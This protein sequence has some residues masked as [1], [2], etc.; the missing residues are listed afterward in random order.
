MV[1][2]VIA[3]M[4]QFVPTTVLTQIVT[5]NGLKWSDDGGHYVTITDYRG[6]ERLVTIPAS[7]NSKPVRSI[8]AWAFNN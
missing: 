4:L 6:K 3:M 5:T 8:G 2:L 7:I 1:L